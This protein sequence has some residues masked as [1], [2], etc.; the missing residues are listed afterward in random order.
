MK[1]LKRFLE[2]R[3]IYLEMRPMLGV[4]HSYY[5]YLYATDAHTA[6]RKKGTLESVSIHVEKRI[7]KLLHGYFKTNSKLPHANINAHEICETLKAIKG[8]PVRSPEHTDELIRI[9]D[10]TF[11]WAYVYRALR[12]FK[13][14]TITVY[15]RK[16][17]NLVVFKGKKYEVIIMRRMHDYKDNK[18]PKSMEGIG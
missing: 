17:D 5:G 3:R 13:N 16:E 4:I 18:T 11:N 14:E 15:Q 6:V 12:V 8:I 10:G 7:S 2:K 9:F 1:T